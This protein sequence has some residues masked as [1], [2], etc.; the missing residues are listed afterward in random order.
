MLDSAGNCG[1]N[2][3]S[4]VALVAQSF[5]FWFKR[6]RRF[7]TTFLVRFHFHAK[8]IASCEFGLHKENDTP[9]LAQNELFITLLREVFVR[10]KC[11]S[12]CSNSTNVTHCERQFTS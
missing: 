7:S 1:L 5:Y 4:P 8:D 3:F 9:E 11:Q 12:I 6:K 10:T 2:A